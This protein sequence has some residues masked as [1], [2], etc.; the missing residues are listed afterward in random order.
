MGTTGALGPIGPQG[1]TG[2]TGSTGPTGPTGSGLTN[3]V[4]ST[5]ATSQTT[6]STTYAD[7]AT[8][9]PSVTATVPATGKVLVTL[10]SSLANSNNGV[11]SFMGFV[12]DAGTASDTTAL[13]STGGAGDTNQLSATYVV[14]GLSAGSRTFTAKYRVASQTGTFANR[15]IIV[16]PL[17]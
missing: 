5:V 4:N 1:T 2:A 7:L 15:S 14:S 9:G 17:P 16:V 13:R 11:A 3:L 10:T 12:V 8:V 6:T